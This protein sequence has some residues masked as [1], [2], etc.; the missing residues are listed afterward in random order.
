LTRASSKHPFTG[1]GEV[2]GD[3]EVGGAV[4]AVVVAGVVAGVVVVPVNCV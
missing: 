1:V 3:S 4:T 2:E